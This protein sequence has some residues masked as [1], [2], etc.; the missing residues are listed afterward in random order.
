MLIKCYSRDMHVICNVHR[1]TRDVHVIIDDMH[2]I[3]TKTDVIRSCTS[4]DTCTLTVTLE[5]WLMIEYRKQSIN[6][7]FT[8]IRCIVF[9]KEIMRNVIESFLFA[10]YSFFILL[11]PCEGTGDDFKSR[12]Q[13][14]LLRWSF[15][16]ARLMHNLTLNASSYFG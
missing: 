2:V 3:Y 9:L 5:K 14:F 16:G 6:T 15:L 4:S 7:L 13:E 11:Q 1:S 8:K 10:N 12:A